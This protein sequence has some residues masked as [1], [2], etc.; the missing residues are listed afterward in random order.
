MRRHTVF[1]WNEIVVPIIS[2][3]PFLGLVLLAEYLRGGR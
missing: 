2:L 1:V 3:F